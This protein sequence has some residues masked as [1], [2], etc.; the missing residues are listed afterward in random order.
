MSKRIVII[1]GGVIGLCCAYYAVKRGFR[2]T[3]LDR[4]PRQRDGCS[5]GNAG[6]VVPSHFVPLAAP[7]MARLGLKWMLNPES[8]FYIKPRWDGDL[9]DWG[10][11]FFRAANAAHVE[12]AAPVLRDLNFA[13]RA[14][15]EELTDAAQGIGDFGLAKRGLLMLCKTPHALDEEAKFAARANQLGVPAEV[16]DAKQIAALDPG[17]TMDVAGAVF[18]PKDAHLSPHRFMAALQTGCE[19]LG[20]EFAWNCEAVGAR[21]KAGRLEAVAIAS[22]AQESILR[23]GENGGA[24]S[25]AQGGHLRSELGADEFVLAGGAWSPGLARALG[26]RLPMQAGKGYS[27]TLPHPRQVPGV[28][29]IFTEARVA[30]TPMGGALRFGGT[31]EIGG[32]DGGINAARVRGIINAV[33]RY[34]PE[35]TPGDFAEVQPWCGLRPCSPDGLPYLGRAARFSNLTI[36]TGHAMMGLSLAP[37]TGCLVG[38]LIAGERPSHDLGLLAP[39]R[40]A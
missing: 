18:F 24:S 27:L 5:Y 15:F 23:A 14:C 35:F 9:W 2:V 34:F 8:P 28:P 37:I 17:V 33:P 29:C 6:L 11:K 25:N 7:G 39:D 13:S 40:F 36:A 16:L 32:L 26:L 22:G 19:R 31:M 10:I 30:V 3:V 21:V 20:V 38:Q 4:N 12:R 1:G